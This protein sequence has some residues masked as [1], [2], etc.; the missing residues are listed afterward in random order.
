MNIAASTAS[1]SRA[2]KVLPQDA[3]NL[4][5]HGPAVPGRDDAK[6]C[7]RLVVKSADRKRCHDTPPTVISVPSLLAMMAMMALRVA[8]TPGHAPGPACLMGVCQDQHCVRC[9]EV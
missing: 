8:L 6:P 9:Y 7:V 4:R 5:L 2:G 3:A 1:S